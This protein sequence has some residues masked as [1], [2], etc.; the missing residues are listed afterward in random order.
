MRQNTKTSNQLFIRTAA[1]LLHAV[2]NFIFIS[3]LTN[4]DLTGSWLRFTGFV[5]AILALVYFFLKHIVSFL[6]FVKK[7]LR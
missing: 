3:W 5:L 1:L 6:Q 7:Q 2:L 4:F